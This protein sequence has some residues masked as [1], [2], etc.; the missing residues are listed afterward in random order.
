MKS[1][2]MLNCKQRNLKRKGGVKEGFVTIINSSKNGRR[3]LLSSKLTS[4]L[5]IE[6]SVHI[7]FLDNQ[8]AIKAC[9]PEE[10][11]AFMLKKHGKKKILYSSEAVRRIVEQLRL[12]FKDRVSYTFYNV[13]LDTYEDQIVAKFKKEESDN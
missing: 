4:E 11:G 5:H 10:E 1:F 7:G 13:E 12:D 2:E 6:N 8:L 3:I 9:S